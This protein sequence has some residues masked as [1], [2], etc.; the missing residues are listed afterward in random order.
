MRSTHVQAT[1]GNYVVG[2]GHPT[3][4]IAEIG[5]THAGDVEQAL[6]LIEIAAELGAQAVKLQTVNPDYSYVPGT[7][8][9]QVFQTLQ[10]SLDDMMRMKNAAKAH[11]LVLFSTPG[12]FPSLDLVKR[13]DFE[14]MK[15]SSGLMTNKPL[16]EAVA[17]LGKPMIISTGMAYLDE[18]ARSVRFAREAGARELVVLHCTSLYPCPD[19][20]LNL[21]AIPAMATALGV[22]VGFS[23]HS[24]DELAAPIAVVV[25]ACAVEK[26][27]ALS[28]EL[29][30]PE[31]GTACDP[32][33]F[34]KMVKGIRRAE[35]M[36][37]D[38]VKAPAP[39]EAH[40]RVVHRRT[41]I[42]CKAIPKGGKFSAEN[43]SVMRGT[44]AHIGITPE[45][46]DSLIGL[47]A[48]RDIARGEPVKL[49]LVAEKID[50]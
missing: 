44:E 30:G 20:R 7:L 14:I 8:S 43:V 45:L 34:R 49:G 9:H 38:G 24:R 36:R 15:V 47:T 37:G 2:D 40:G 41:I 32:D 6:K 35:A 31:K 3:F 18:V 27:L 10:L 22:P 1:F 26:H 16:V 46:F 13:A 23:D 48:A 39:E 42:A 4:V 29:A 19:Q 12:D 11:G 50:G 17:R 21:S 28:H 33:Q 5:A 25:G